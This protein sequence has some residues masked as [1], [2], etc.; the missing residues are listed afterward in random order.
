MPH[1]SCNSHKTSVSCY[2]IML[3]LL[4][5]YD[6]CTVSCISIIF[7]ILN[8]RICFFHQTSHC[9]T[10]FCLGLFTHHLKYLL[11]TLDLVFSNRLMLLKS[12]LQ[13]FRCSILC[14]FLQ[15]LY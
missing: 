12:I 2:F 5:T 3:G 9:F 7:S 1:S 15:A 6:K 13:V 11:E 4:S 14:H 8:N 10:F